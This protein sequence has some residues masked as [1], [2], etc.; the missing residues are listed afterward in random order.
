MWWENVNYRQGGVEGVN[1]GTEMG[2]KP[3]FDFL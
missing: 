1:M 3:P 2:I